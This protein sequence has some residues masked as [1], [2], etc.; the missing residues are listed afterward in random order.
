MKL[1]NKTFGS[2]EEVVGFVKNNKDV[3]EKEEDLKWLT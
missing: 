1:L 3:R 2:I